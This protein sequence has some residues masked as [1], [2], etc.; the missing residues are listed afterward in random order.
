M[1]VNDRG[2]EVVLGVDVG[3]TKVLMGLVSRE[4]EILLSEKRLVVW[5]D[6][7]ALL[8]AIFDAADSLLARAGDAFKLLAVGIGIKGHVQENR[9]I[10]SSIMGGMVEY[11]F[12][13][14][15]EAHFHLPVWIDNDVNAATMAEAILGAGRNND[16]FV[17]VNIGTGSAVGIYDQGRLVRGRTN[18]SGEIGNM[19][20]RI[21]QEDRL[22]CLEDV[23]SGKGLCDETRRLA[24]GFP[25]SALAG[26]AA[27][28]QLSAIQVFEAWHAGD[29]LAREVVGR[30]VD[31]LAT[32]IINFECMLGS[33]LYIFGGGVISE[34]AFFEQVCAR[35][36]AIRSQLGLSFPFE[37]RVSALG[38]ANVG[39][40]G[41]A[42]VAFS[43]I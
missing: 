28:E 23:A 40:L 16:F 26:K 32:S 3:G 24:A 12:V 33:G 36:Q 42:S 7:Q 25:D 37:M 39:L 4:G 19:V 9:L 21:P 43:E 10:S 2:R 41:A 35:V 11:D 15:M 17:Y 22:F 5:G 34:P 1:S 38:A 13:G 20:C 27:K 18:F 6:G 31:I 14:L 8:E 29:P 30:A